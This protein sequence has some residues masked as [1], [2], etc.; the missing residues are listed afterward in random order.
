MDCVA[1]MSWDAA[2]NEDPLNAR[3]GVIEVSNQA[4]LEDCD[5]SAEEA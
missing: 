2:D 4:A 1:A 3:V 5:L